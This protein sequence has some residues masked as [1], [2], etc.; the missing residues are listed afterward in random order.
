MYSICNN[1]SVPLLVKQV[2]VYDPGEE[3]PPRTT[4][5]FAWSD[6]SATSRSVQ[7][8]PVAGTK[9]ELETLAIP[10]YSLD[11]VATLPSF[12]VFK[13]GWNSSLRC[14]VELY[15]SGAT[16]VLVIE[17]EGQDISED[18]FVDVAKSSVVEF[19]LHFSLPGMALRRPN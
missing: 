18:D 7:V 11:E 13:Q 16:K 4:V 17:E 1:T 5:P 3:V 8:L 12:K 14:S 19:A 15:L 6:P 9:I 10:R 2:D